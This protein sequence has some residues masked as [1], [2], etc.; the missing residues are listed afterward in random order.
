[1]WH[2]E[3]D[4]REKVM[5][6]TRLVVSKYHEAGMSCLRLSGGYGRKPPLQKL[7]N[8]VVQ[9]DYWDQSLVTR[10][11]GTEFNGSMWSMGRTKA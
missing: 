2:K 11:H 3:Y 6:A 10:I 9:I 4:P 1:M 5:V 7:R 8:K